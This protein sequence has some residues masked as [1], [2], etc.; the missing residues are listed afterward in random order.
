[1]KGLQQNRSDSNRLLLL[2]TFSLSFLPFW[3]SIKIS[4]KRNPSNITL[5]HWC[6][7]LASQ[8]FLPSPLNVEIAPTDRKN[9]AN[10]PT[11]V[12]FFL[13]PDLSLTRLYA[14]AQFMTWTSIRR[15]FGLSL[16]IFSNADKDIYCY[17]YK[18]LQKTKHSKRSREIVTTRTTPHTMLFHSTGKKSVESYGDSRFPDQYTLKRNWKRQRDRNPNTTREIQNQRPPQHSTTQ[19]RTIKVHNQWKLNRTQERLTYTLPELAS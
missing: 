13:H 2:L 6:F 18:K 8:S 7:F 9:S 1:M 14:E 16:Q 17:V 10:G 11:S 12:F 5:M 3:R 4:I 15:H 19:H